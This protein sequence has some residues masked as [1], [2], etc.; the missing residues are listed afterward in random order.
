MQK[1]KRISFTFRSFYSIFIHSSTNPINLGEI[2]QA[3]E[4]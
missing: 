1:K 3:E 2:V 4:L